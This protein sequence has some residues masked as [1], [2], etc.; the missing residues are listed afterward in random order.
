MSEKTIAVCDL[1]PNYALN[2]SGAL[3]QA[4]YGHFNISTFTSSS[5]L[6]EYLAAHDVDTAIIS[7]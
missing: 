4:L 2:L 6:C 1:D 7:E 5:A 3:D